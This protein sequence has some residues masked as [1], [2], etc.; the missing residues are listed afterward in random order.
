MCQLLTQ[1]HDS[2]SSLISCLRDH[3]DFLHGLVPSVFQKRNFIVSLLPSLSASSRLGLWC[4]SWTLLMSS[5]GWGERRSYPPSGTCL[6]LHWPCSEP[7]LCTAVICWQRGLF[8][9]VNGFLSLTSLPEE[10]GT[11]NAS[12]PA[13]LLSMR[14]KTV[15]WYLKNSSC[16][17]A[18]VWASR[19]DGKPF[20][21][22]KNPALSYLF[23]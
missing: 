20:L 11:R 6:G 21:L 18:L 15:I 7:S 12:S 9:V 17:A 23:L 2:M 19:H 4:L 16:F 13:E 10:P 3:K 5:L 14:Q 22:K 8:C 1:Q